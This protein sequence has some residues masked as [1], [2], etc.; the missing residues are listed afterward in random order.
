MKGRIFT[1]ISLLCLIAV[2]ACRKGEL[3]SETYYGGLN[4]NNSALSLVAMDVYMDGNK[5]G[6]IKPGKGVDLGTTLVAGESG[7]LTVYK[8]DS[9]HTSDNFIADSIIVYPKNNKTSLDLI[10]SDLLQKKGFWDKSVLA[11]PAD[12]VRIR[13]KYVSTVAVPSPTGL[14]QPLDAYNIQL[15]NGVPKTATDSLKNVIPLTKSNYSQDITI[16]KTWDIYYRLINP[17]TGAI[18]KDNTTNYYNHMYNFGTSTVYGGGTYALI[19]ITISELSGNYRLTYPA[20]V[21]KVN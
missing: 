3:A 17:A 21:Q 15:I 11:V 12:S 5:I 9:A 19:T 18:L 6:S 16:P 4:I 1:A 20:T 2:T 8:A 10:Y 13:I 14:A 7:H